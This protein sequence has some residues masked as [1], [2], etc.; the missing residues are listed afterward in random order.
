MDAFEY[1]ALDPSGKE[2]RGVLEG[3]SP[4]QVRQ[5]LRESGLTP[6]SIDSASGTATQSKS[7]LFQRQINAME[8][9]LITRQMATLLRSGLPLEHVLKTTAQQTD[10]RHVERTLLAVRAKVL[11]GRTL[12]DGLKDFPKTF[13]EVY[14]QTVSSG[15]ESGHLEVVLERL[16]DYTE[17]RQQMRQKTIFALFYP[18]LLTIV[19][20]LIVGGL[21]TYIVPQVTRVFES[22]SAELPW[23]TQALMSTSDTLRSYGVPIFVTLLALGLFF[24]YLLK[25]P[26][27]KRWW[28]RTLL[29]IPLVGRLVRTANAARFSR[30]LSIM[31]AS[32]VPILDSMRIA[33]QVLTNLPMRSAVEEATLRVRE[34]ASL[35]QALDKTGYFPPMTLSLLASGESSGNLEGMLERSADIQEREIETLVSTIQGLFEPILILVMGGI[36]LVIVLAILLPIFDLNQLVA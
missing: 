5:Q 3:D 27:P 32:S 23:I 15:E 13:P 8:L 1:V 35:Y 16:A 9:A 20:L 34:G 6:L 2:K 33:S 28:H 31:A 17:Q 14:I 21:L 25:K 7:K 29:R 26:G 18:A 22:M 19:S 4:R 30:T 11:E 36:V 12:A 24:S 10:K